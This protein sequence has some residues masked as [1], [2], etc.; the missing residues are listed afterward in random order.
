MSSFSRTLATIASALSI[1]NL[2]GTFANNLA[3]TANTTT[4]NLIVTSNTTTGNLTVTGTTAITGGSVTIGNSYVNT[5]S[6]WVGN[7]T[8][9]TVMLNNSIKVANSTSSITITPSSLS[10]SNVTMTMPAVIENVSLNSY[11]GGASGTMNID[12][13]TSP[14]VYYINSS[15]SGS[16][17]I[18]FRGN[19]STTANSILSSG[20]AISATLLATQGLAGANYYPTTF[21]IDSVAYTPIWQNGI[22]PSSGDA[23]STDVYT[24]TIIKTSTTPTY[25]ILASQTK[26][27]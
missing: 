22:T 11:F 18:N 7:S 17:T 10:F 24:F 3:V 27:T 19:S 12:L 9:N 13:L 14:I 23:S 5:T 15:T 16:W 20:Q 26:Y 25:T 1:T 2:N 21:T 8:A 6:F 4:N